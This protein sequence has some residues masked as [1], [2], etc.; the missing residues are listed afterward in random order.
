MY[1]CDNWNDDSTV[2][3][4]TRRPAEAHLASHS[5]NTPNNISNIKKK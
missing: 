3:V 2:E 5:N 4:L 1:G